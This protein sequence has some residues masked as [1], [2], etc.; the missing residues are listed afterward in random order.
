M[1][2]HDACHELKNIQYQT[3]LINS[4][5][6]KKVDDDEVNKIDTFLST[7]KKMNCTKTWNKLGKAMKLK[8][9]VDFIDE[10]VI[11]NKINSKKKQELKQYLLTC[12]HRKKLQRVKDVVYSV[13]EG[14]IIDIP[15]LS[16]NKNKFTLK[17]VDRKNTTSKCLAHIRKKKLI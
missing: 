5:I 8:K 17:R 6:P 10:Y 3:M 16:Y 2:K 14:K 9:I 15:G 4:K 1:S 13:E 12:L 7:E 11:K